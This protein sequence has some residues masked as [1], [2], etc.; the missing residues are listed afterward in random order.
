MTDWCAAVFIILFVSTVLLSLR[1]VA[2]IVSWLLHVLKHAGV[3]PTL[4]CA[5]TMIG[6]LLLYRHP[7]KLWLRKYH[8]VVH[9]TI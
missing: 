2:D 6:S 7:N 1:H 3:R 9:V 4:D 5:A 8:C